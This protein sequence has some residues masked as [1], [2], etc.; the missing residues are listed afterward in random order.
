MGNADDYGAID[1]CC[2]RRNWAD[3]SC[4]GSSLLWRSTDTDPQPPAGPYRVYLPLVMS[5]GSGSTQ[6]VWHVSTLSLGQYYAK[7]ELDDG[8]TRRAGLA[9]RRW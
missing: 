6:S 1:M 4:E 5:G 2:F 3:A 7:I 9:T 8:L